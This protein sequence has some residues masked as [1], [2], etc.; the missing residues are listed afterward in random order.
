MKPFKI[1]GIIWTVFKLIS[2][3]SLIGLSQF[4]GDHSQ[5]VIFIAS[6]IGSWILGLIFL[7]AIIKI[8]WKIE[9]IKKN[10]VIHF[11]FNAI[12]LV[13]F[14]SLM[15]IFLLFIEYVTTS[16]SWV[17]LWVIYSKNFSKVFRDSFLTYNFL[18]GICYGL[19][20]YH[21]KKEEELKLEKVEKQLLETRMLYLKSQLRPHFLFNALNAVSSLID[22]DKKKAQ[23]ILVDLSDLLRDVLEFDTRNKISLKEELTMLE[24]Y[25]QIE[26]ARFSDSL[27]ITIV[28]PDEHLNFLIPSFILQ[29]IVENSIKHGFSDSRLNITLTSK[30]H[31]SKFLITVTDDGLGLN[32]NVKFGTGLSN[33][34]TRIK[35]IYGES[36]S[37]SLRN[38]ADGRG[39]INEIVLPIEKYDKDTHSG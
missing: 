6:N 19:N 4:E 14:S 7:Y 39:V 29:P 21:F 13:M 35:E 2:A 37:F 9:L 3:L 23:S 20:Y 33:I 30:I 27:N 28:I 17:E 22:E 32:Q 25:F 18:I 15:F 34:S 10:W 11:V 5:Y 16:F 24:K 36:F 26:L 31:D 8:I 1:I 12:S 38:R